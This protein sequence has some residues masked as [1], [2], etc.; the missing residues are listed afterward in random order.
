MSATMIPDRR[1][2]GIDLGK[3]KS[4]ACLYSPVDGEFQFE[5]FVMRKENLAKLLA[6]S[7]SATLVVAARP[8]AGRFGD[9]RS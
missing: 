5:S 6:R 2:L 7:K 1:I 9:L 8:L 4:V 3:F